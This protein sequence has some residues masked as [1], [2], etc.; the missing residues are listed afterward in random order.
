MLSIMFMAFSKSPFCLFLL[1]QGKIQR[2][3]CHE[4]C[5]NRCVAVCMVFCDGFALNRLQLGKFGQAFLSQ[6][7]SL[8]WPS[9]HK[10]A[11]HV[12]LL[13]YLELLH[14]LSLFIVFASW[15]ALQRK[16]WYNLMTPLTSEF[17]KCHL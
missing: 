11:K 16:S 15:H 4:Y 6:G 14:I 12:V 10:L 7:S 9:E 3:A 17:L 13:T 8:S 5:R 2:R 1:I